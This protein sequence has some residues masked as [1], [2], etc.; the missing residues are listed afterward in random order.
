MSVKI[1][2]PKMASDTSV[3]ILLIEIWPNILCHNDVVFSLVAFLFIPREGYCKDSLYEA[4]ESIVYRLSL[5]IKNQNQPTL[6]HE[7]N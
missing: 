1:K 6:N 3:S 4:M 5:T 7:T 2:G